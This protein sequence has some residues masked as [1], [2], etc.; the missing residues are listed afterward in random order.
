MKKILIPLAL[1]VISSVAQA[2]EGMWMP[3]QLPQ[4]SAQLRAAGLQLDP[5]TLT[6]LTEFP[7]GAIVSLGGCSASFVSP[8][9]LVITNHHCVYGSVAHNSTPANNL[10]ANGFLAHQLSEELP[11]APG[12]RIFVTKEVNKVSS[13]VIDAQVATLSGKARLDAIEKN[14]KALVA[15]CEADVGHRCTV[16]P[17]YGGLDYYLIKQLEIRD[18]RLV[19]APAEGIGKFGGDTDNWMWPRHTGDY[20]FYRAYVSKDGKAADYNK[21]NVPYL[22]QHFLKLAKDGLKEG[23]F[24]MALGYPGRTNRHRLPSE[25]AHTFSWSYPSYVSSSAE[26]LAIIARETA[27]DPD[28]KLKYAS[29]VA[30]I[31]NYYKNRQGMLESYA[32]SDF[33]ARKT[34]Q[35][36]ALKSWV[37]SDATR[38]QTYGADIARIEQ[39]ISERDASE[40]RDFYLDR[41]FPRLLARAHDLYR[42]ANESRQPDSA[43]K[44]GYQVRDL[45]R[46]QASLDAIERSY[47]AKVD[48]AL[49]FNNL[50]HYAAAP[51]AQHDAAFDAAL[52][53]QA[54]MSDAALSA[55]L[56][57]LYA[58]SELND[59]ALRR[60]WLTKTPEQFRASHDPFIQTAV[61]MYAGHLKR[62]AAEEELA[63]KIQQAYA[64]YMQA[65][66]AYMESQG[67]AIY[68]DANSTLR[69]TFGRVA[70]RGHG[71]ADGMAWSAFTT[72]AGI[73]AKATGSGEFNAPAAELAAIKAKDFGKYVDPYLK[74]VPVAY[75]ATLDI[76]G[77]NSGSAALNAR[78]ELI[79]LAFDGTL[80]SIISDW[81]YNPANTRSIQVDL[82][83]IL[84][85]MKHVDHA[86]ALIREMGAE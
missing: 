66:I 72:L 32:N 48:Q 43:R 69:V 25:V 68:P 7:M 30:G 50:K 16:Y 23:D 84:W 75:L 59:P 1:Q 38:R 52:G 15:A 45:P 36:E 8:Q 85:V 71:G 33:L 64:N 58:A 42:L 34:S 26:A 67:Q 86:D 20:G 49:V 21:D 2:D 13:K 5:A 65:K 10:L 24:V 4:V 35:H 40:Q 62:E 41:S 55:R 44:A 51:A 28:A 53:I 39:L 29:Q 80:D 11:A 31:N 56:D 19:H 54:G 82:R 81:D 78:G 77:G 73:S 83:Y 3:Q 60:A 37:N 61:A 17:Y 47:V 79:G 46:I 70:G 27:S 76:T 18:V 63:G 6:K 12:A 22:P 14:S 57:R 9:G 74:A